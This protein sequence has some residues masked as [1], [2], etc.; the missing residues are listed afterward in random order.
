MNYFERKKKRQFYL[1]Y[2]DNAVWTLPVTEEAYRIWGF[3]IAC[4]GVYDDH[5]VA[6]A[7]EE[8]WELCGYHHRGYWG[9]IDTVTDLL[10]EK[11]E[12]LRYED[13]GPDYLNVIE[14]GQRQRRKKYMLAPPDKRFGGRLEDFRQD[15]G[16]Q[17][18][19]AY[20]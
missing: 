10:S 15:P 16:F 9:W 1:Y 2:P 5:L 18:R 17:A 13:V 7:L 19:G 3:C 4:P 6:H 12:A 14:F 8:F 11:H 20:L